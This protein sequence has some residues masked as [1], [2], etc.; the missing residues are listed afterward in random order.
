MKKII[1]KAINFIERNIFKIGLGLVI[2]TEAHI[3][4]TES[5]GYNAIGGEFLIVPL[6]ILTKYL[7]VGL[8]DFYKEYKW[9]IE[10]GYTEWSEID[11]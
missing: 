3:K 9:E 6:I 11:E 5:R 10:Y 1:K 2:T 4:A 7:V 8:K